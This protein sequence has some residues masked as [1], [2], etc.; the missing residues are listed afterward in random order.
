MLIETVLLN[1]IQNGDVVIHKGMFK[2]VSEGDIQITSFG[3]HDNGAKKI[4][5]DVFGTRH[6]RKTINR[7]VGE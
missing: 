2:E 1:D 3:K 7:K 5:C 6:F 4:S